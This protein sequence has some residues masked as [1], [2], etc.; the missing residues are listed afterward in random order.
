MP[1]FRQRGS[2]GD[3]LSPESTIG[4]QAGGGRYVRTPLDVRID[5]QPKKGKGAVETKAP[6]PGESIHSLASTRGLL[7]QLAKESDATSTASL[8]S[9]KASDISGSRQQ[10]YIGLQDELRDIRPDEDSVAR[11]FLAFKP[12]A[13]TL[14]RGTGNLKTLTWLGSEFGEN[15]LGRIHASNPDLSPSSLAL[16]KQ[17]SQWFAKEAMALLQAGH[18]TAEG[19]K[20]FMAG[21]AAGM[22]G[23]RNEG[24]HSTHLPPQFAEATFGDPSQAALYEAL[25]SLTSREKSALTSTACQA[26]LELAGEVNTLPELITRLFGQGAG[27]PQTPVSDQNAPK[28]KAAPRRSEGHIGTVNTSAPKSS[29]EKTATPKPEAPL[30]HE[31]S[32]EAQ[33]KISESDSR[34]VY[35]NE[36]REMQARIDQLSKQDGKTTSTATQREIIELRDQLRALEARLAALER[37]PSIVRS[38]NDS[39]MQA[40]PHD[41]DRD[42]GAGP[43]PTGGIQ[44]GDRVETKKESYTHGAS[45]PDLTAGGGRTLSAQ[46]EVAASFQV[47]SELPSSSSAGSEGIRPP[48]RQATDDRSIEPAPSQGTP[49]PANTEHPPW[50][51]NKHSANG[52]DVGLDDAN[53][54]RLPDLDGLESTKRAESA[55][56]QTSATETTSQLQPSIIRAK[57][58]DQAIIEFLDAAQDTSTPE[59]DEAAQAK[60]EQ[61]LLREL[62][63]EL[64]LEEEELAV[65]EDSFALEQEEAVAP[66][67]ETKSSAPSEQIPAVP[68]VTPRAEEPLGTSRVTLNS[69][70][71]ETRTQARH[72]DETA[73]QSSV[74]PIGGNDMPA[75][76]SDAAGVNAGRIASFPS[77]N[78]SSDFSVTDDTT[79]TDETSVDEDDLIESPVPSDTSSDTADVSVS[80]AQRQQTPEGPLSQDERARTVGERMA[81]DLYAEDVP[82]V[83]IERG[84]V[85]ALRLLASIRFAEDSQRIAAFHGFAGGTPPDQGTLLARTMERVAL[86]MTLEAAE[87][88]T[89]EAIITVDD[90]LPF[91]HGTQAGDAPVEAPAFA[92]L[93]TRREAAAAAGNLASLAQTYDRASTARTIED[94]A[95]I[96]HARRAALQQMAE[97]LDGRIAAGNP[98]VVD[99]SPTVQ[100]TQP[101]DGLALGD[102]LD[103]FERSNAPAGVSQAGG[104]AGPSSPQESRPDARPGT[105]ARTQAPSP[106]ATQT[107][108]S[109]E[110]QQLASVITAGSQPP[111]PSTGPQTPPSGAGAQVQVPPLEG[112]PVVTSAPA[113]RSPAPGPDAAPRQAVTASRFA[114]LIEALL[115]DSAEDDDSALASAREMGEEIAQRL[116]VLSNPDQ[117]HILWELFDALATTRLNIGDRQSPIEL[118]L[119]GAVLEAFLAPVA[120]TIDDPVVAALLVDSAAHSRD[121]GN[122]NAADQ[123]I[124]FVA[125]RFVGLNRDRPGEDH[126]TPILQALNTL[127]ET[128]GPGQESRT[129][130]IAAIRA[131]VLTLPRERKQ[132]SPANQEVDLSIYEIRKMVADIQAAGREFE[133][134]LNDSGKPTAG[135]VT[136]SM[137]DDPLPA[138][139]AGPAAPE[140][141]DIDLSGVVQAVRSRASVAVK[142]QQSLVLAGET[143]GADAWAA[144]MRE[145]QEAMRELGPDIGGLAIVKDTKSDASVQAMN[146]TGVGRTLGERLAAAPQGPA[147]GRHLLAA[148]V[149]R[150]GVGAGLEDLVQGL[151]GAIPDEA[152]AGWAQS[153][154]EAYASLDGQRSH[155]AAFRGVFEALQARLAKASQAAGD[156]ETLGLIGEALDSTIRALSDNT[157]DASQAPGF[158][159]AQEGIPATIEGVREQLTQVQRDLATWMGQSAPEEVYAPWHDHAQK[160]DKAMRLI[161]DRLARFPSLNDPGTTPRHRQ[162]SWNDIGVNFSGKLDLQRPDLSAKASQVRDALNAVTQ[163]ISDEAH[164]AELLEG[165]VRSASEKNLPLLAKQALA[166][167]HDSSDAEHATVTLRTVF[168]MLKERVDPRMHAP[169]RAAALRDTRLRI[170]G[171]IREAR[172]AS[173]TNSTEG[174]LI[175]LAGETFAPDASRRSHESKALPKRGA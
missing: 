125:Q 73:P 145:T 62:E 51:D 89:D 78:E 68:Q 79:S 114:P 7:V 163:R 139:A 137:Q 29:G 38:T 46:H 138:Q 132:L 98:E 26:G 16:E 13:S 156:E 173:R 27:H 116:A 71:Q 24:K 22:R 146:W 41:S 119:E 33:P 162:V 93:M 50:P 100:E 135:A 64:A 12:C 8:K 61:Q 84:M 149:S 131:T 30:P 31:P 155:P 127:A 96:R 81:A 128:T 144:L 151:L 66:A 118:G 107:V 160:T 48:S 32:V 86:A 169:E 168:E 82:R 91:G 152:L 103:V 136:P 129:K 133:E 21:F 165:L 171:A 104:S 150:I 80:E 140:P 111:G 143:R 87:N 72:D 147:Q 59:L 60:A 65:D 94:L 74:N 141:Q 39:T 122:W 1:R 175:T 47:A 76:R 77:R 102:V 153:G 154:F 123:A 45:R 6:R 11:V 67:I 170:E 157:R 113:R 53:P 159:P 19:F 34:A 142:L 58:V 9:R 23:L 70:A 28:A 166:C 108:P 101:A 56:T 109:L 148:A 167:A 55:A 120:G 35:V 112:A 36:L 4:Y 20:V 40:G 121:S 110:P 88:D 158:L 126:R 85:T 17:A 37:A 49:R 172:A 57:P 99:E 3:R 106:T 42:A 54:L 164:L 69:K 117:V 105:E 92:P 130:A 44:T 2:P 25:E 75:E 43:G 5:E 10:A 18:L 95:A 124:S 134:A 83:D 52:R 14:C 115:K 63:E 97:L 15:L 90:V 174:R 161:A